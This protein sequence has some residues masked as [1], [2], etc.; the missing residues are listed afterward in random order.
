[1]QYD[2]RKVNGPK[3]NLP[4]HC[5]EVFA[6][7]PDTKI[8]IGTDSQNYDFKTT[9]V[10]VIAFRY[11]QRGVH[12]IYRKIVYDWNTDQRFRDNWYRLYHEAELSV[13]AAKWID[14][15]TPYDVISI[16]L[17][18]NSD[19]A[20]LSNTVLSAGKGLAVASGYQCN[21][22][23]DSQIAAKAADNFCR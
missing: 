18:Y 6:E 23:P 13:A 9:Y 12:C 22:K 21:V 17:D 1:M 3:V 20:Y 14:A 16:D 19:P 5:N 7:N 2:F 4:K 15:N 10:T 8:I 11:N